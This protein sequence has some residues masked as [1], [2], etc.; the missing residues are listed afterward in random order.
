MDETKFFWQSFFSDTKAGKEREA[1][2]EMCIAELK[3][4][5]IQGGVRNIV[6]RVYSHGH[7]TNLDEV[8]QVFIDVGM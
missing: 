6:D 4:T 1:E 5:A 3:A 7:S 2:L 8:Y